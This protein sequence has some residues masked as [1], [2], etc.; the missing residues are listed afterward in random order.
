M[1]AASGDPLMQLSH[2][3]QL[4]G[5]DRRDEAVAL[6]EELRR[7]GG[8]G[9]RGRGFGARRRSQS[10]RSAMTT[11]SRLLEDAA[12]DPQ[13]ADGLRWQRARIAEERGNKIGAARLYQ[14]IQSGPRALAAQLRA[15]RLL[16]EQG[17]PELAEMLIDDFL[18]AVPG[19]HG[20]RG[21]GRRG[22]PRGGGQGRRG[23]RPHRSRARA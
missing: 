4:L 3:W 18:A 21:L 22:D 15:Y 17:A 10:T 2:A 7:G 14:G 16:R 11:R 5:D 13:Q 12:R 20:G 23:D 19:G 6:F 1:L 8:P 9:G